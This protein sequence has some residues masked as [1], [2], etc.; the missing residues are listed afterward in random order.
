MKRQHSTLAMAGNINLLGNSGEV[1]ISTT[2]L[3]EQTLKK[4]KDNMEKEKSL[5]FR[6]NTNNRGYGFQ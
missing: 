1:S 5:Q 2:Q 6:S 3:N 4:V